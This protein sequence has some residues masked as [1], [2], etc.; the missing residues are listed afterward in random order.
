MGTEFK[1]PNKKAV[2]YWPV[3]TGDSTTLIL[4]PGEIAMQID[5]RHLEKA[6]D[7]NN[8]EWP[9]IDYLVKVLPK[10]NNRPYLALFVLTHPDKDHIQGFAE[11]LKKV[12][13]GELWH[14]PR[15]FRDQKDE[16]SLC[17]D[18]K[19]F[20][21]EADRRRK[22]IL[23]DPNNIKSGNRLRVI[24]HDDILRE[25]KYK[26]LPDE[27]KSRP[28]EKVSIVDGSN[29]S[30]DFQAFIHAP[31]KDDQ[32]R[33]RNNTSLSL[34]IVI[35]DG[36]KYGQFFF[37]GDREYPTIKQIFE[38]TEEK[39]NN[40]YLY[41]NAMLCA[42]HCS[43]AVMYWQDEGEK[44]EKLKQ[45][46]MDY[47]KKYSRVGYIISSSLADFTDGDGDNPPHKKARKRYEEIVKAGRFIC[48]HEYPNKENPYPFVCVIDSEGFSV[49]EKREAGKGP[50][51]LSVAVQSA[52][53][54][55]QPPT[56]QVGFGRI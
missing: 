47:F 20:R 4:K 29:L 33:D 7:S 42:H 11:L 19:A 55:A 32:A 26:N 13:V 48:T 37:F 27:C 28:G 24:G 8:P 41:W 53:G 16:E 1:L 10:K 15:I 34:N 45:D 54:G 12:D 46:I 35:F 3:G 5:L 43:K 6:D 51:A 36:K 14:T 25:E 30:N 18:A 22:A 9:I 49:Q 44:E 17:D 39:K 31:F 52:R 23:A 2:V 38:K 56:A 50:A 40:N 21:K